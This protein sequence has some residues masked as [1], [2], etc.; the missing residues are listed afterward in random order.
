MKIYLD[1]CCFNKPFDNQSRIQ[2]KLEAEAKLF[3]QRMVIDKKIELVWSYILEYE[4]VQNPFNERKISIQ[5]WKELCYSNILENDEVLDK[6]EEIMLNGI[7]PKDSLHISCAVFGGCDYFITTDYKLINKSASI[8]EIEII[9]PLDFI[10]I[11][12]KEEDQ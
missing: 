8:K 12:E 4:N 3:I 11:L 5:D 6:A 2:V 1:N 10:S 9:N 7:R